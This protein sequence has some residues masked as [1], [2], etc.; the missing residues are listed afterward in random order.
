MARGSNP[1]RWPTLL[2]TLCI[3]AL[4]ACTTLGPDYQRAATSVQSG[5]SMPELANTASGKVTD[6][7]FWASFSDPTLLE[8]LRHAQ[9]KSLTL[10]SAALQVDAASETV[11]INAASLLPSVSATGSRNYNQPDNASKQKNINAGLF[12]DQVLGQLSWEIDF[13]GK[14][15]R[16]EQADKASLEASKA[17]LESSLVSLKA[18]VANA[19]INARIYANR[20]VVAAANLRE[21]AEN[22][23]IAEARYRLGSN[24]EMDW[25]QAQTQLA[26]TQAQIPV[27]RASLEQNQ[28]ALSVLLGETPDYF[29]KK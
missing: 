8:L 22:L 26:Q 29:A 12:T 16:G 15:R 5:W 28:N 2:A 4:A 27:L 17:A 25:R 20:I 24:S 21:Q 1:R 9:K 6:D 10:Q 7:E 13:W 19:Y 23:R 11:R 14:Y 3:S 18:S